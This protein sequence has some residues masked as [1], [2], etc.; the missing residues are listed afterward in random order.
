MLKRKVVLIT[1]GQPSVNPRLVKE[2]DALYDSG[3]DV[4]VIYQY[5]NDWGAQMDKGLLAERK[6]KA[7]RV[8]GAPTDEKLKYWLSRVV[9]KAGTLL[10]SLINNKT[11]LTEITIGR[12]C[13]LLTAE[14]L[15]HKAHLYIAHNLSA[16]PAAVKAAKKYEAKCGFDAEDFHRNEVS[17][18]AADPDVVLKSAIENK[19]IPMI[20]YLT[21]SSA[22][23]GAAYQNLFADK[24][25]VIVLNTFPIDHQIPTPVLTSNKKLKLFWFSQTIGAKRGIDEVF[26]ALNRLNNKDIEL[27]LLGQL[28]QSAKNYLDAIGAGPINFQVHEPIAAQEINLFASQF[29]IG[30]GLEPGF[31]INNDLALS[32]KIFTYL[33]AGLATIVSNTSAQKALLLQYPEIGKIYER[34]NIP[35]LAAIINYY[36][37]DKDALFK[38]KI[39]SYI[40]AREVLNWE[41]EREKFLTV[42]KETLA[43]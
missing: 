3:Y 9:Y 32:N 39:N 14:A 27:H 28:P 10:T 23:I 33:Q 24:K 15:K 26:A 12:C 34:E 43:A 6:W 7:I 4:T 16:L 42:V 31:C 40:A 35:A 19:Y 20:H 36:F 41:T 17:D 13:Y 1:S 5:W 8:G 11:V 30:L 37:E 29:D 21:A 22:G 38:A 25:P 18:D 2:A